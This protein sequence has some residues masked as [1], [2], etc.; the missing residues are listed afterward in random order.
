MRRLLLALVFVA[1]AGGASAQW[2]NYI[3][4]QPQAINPGAL[5]PCGTSLVFDHTVACNAIAYSLMGK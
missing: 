2:G 5:T 1:A 3:F 4:P